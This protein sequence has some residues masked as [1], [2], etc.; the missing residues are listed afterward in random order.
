MTRASTV[1]Y[2]L[3]EAVR[4]LRDRRVASLLSIATIAASLALV[5]LL[6]TIGRGAGETLAAWRSQLALSV[7]L[8]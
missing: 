2:F 4:D 8:G 3:G 7:F 6:I 5:G 1:R